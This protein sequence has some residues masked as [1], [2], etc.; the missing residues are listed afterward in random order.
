MI[1]VLWPH[2]KNFSKHRSVINLAVLCIHD[3]IQD[4]ETRNFEG[5]NFEAQF[6]LEFKD[7][8]SNI[9]F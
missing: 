5:N 2:S 8:K 9:S 1:A 3:V 7:C 6:I 4:D